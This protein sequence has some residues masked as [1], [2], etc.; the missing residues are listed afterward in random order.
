MSIAWLQVWQLGQVRQTEVCPRS[1][2]GGDKA[3]GGVRPSGVGTRPKSSARQVPLLN[4]SA[5]VAA[6]GN[7]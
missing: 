7:K 6:T 3:G 4:L 2:L 5:G 1:G